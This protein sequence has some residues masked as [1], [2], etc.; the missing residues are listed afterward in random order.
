[1]FVLAT[2]LNSDR[3]ALNLMPSLV[4]RSSLQ[5]CVSSASRVFHPP[6][7]SLLPFVSLSSLQHEHCH[8]LLLPA[9]LPSRARSLPSSS[10]EY[11]RTPRSRVPGMQP[12]MQLVALLASCVIGRTRIRAHPACSAT[13]S[14]FVAFSLSCRLSSF[15][16]AVSRICLWMFERFRRPS[17]SR[18]VLPFS[19]SIVHLNLES[20][21]SIRSRK[22]KF[23]R[24]MKNL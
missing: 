21:N 23:P 7:S 19:F 4:S 24:V 11:S 18:S 22:S 16:R 3:Y 2:K 6:P 17:T 15:T 20:M 14:R 1:M 10:R 8:T 9:A 5:L 13:D 12:I